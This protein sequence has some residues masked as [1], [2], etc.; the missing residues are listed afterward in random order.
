MRQDAGEQPGHLHLGDADPVTVSCLEGAQEG[1]EQHA[2]FSS[3]TLV[4]IFWE[5][6]SQRR[7]LVAAGRVVQE[8]GAK[9]PSLASASMTH[10]LETSRCSAISEGCGERSGRKESSAS[11][12]LI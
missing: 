12:G 10:S 5:Q 2:R 7:R 9:Q 8:I 6:C 11:A 4:V 1:C 3:A